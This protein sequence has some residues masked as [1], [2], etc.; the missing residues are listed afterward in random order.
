MLIALILYML[1]MK[2]SHSFSLEEND[3]QRSTFCSRERLI[4]LV[5]F[6]RDN[7]DGQLQID[8]TQFASALPVSRL[9]TAGKT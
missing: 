9:R 2:T 8:I 6:L 1:D 4:Q 3:D 7:S 5:D